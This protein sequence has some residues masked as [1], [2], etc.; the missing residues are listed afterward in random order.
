MGKL[1][2]LQPALGEWFAILAACETHL[3][4]MSPHRNEFMYYHQP[5]Q[6]TKS[7]VPCLSLFFQKEKEQYTS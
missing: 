1:S 2:P 4:P 5:A 3:G 7:Q 6:Y